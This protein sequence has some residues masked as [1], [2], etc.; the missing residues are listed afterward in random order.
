MKYE[1]QL[2]RWAK[3]AG[4]IAH[5]R[6]RSG[7]TLLLNQLFILPVLAYQYFVAPH[8]ANCCRFYPCCSDY[9]KAAIIKHGVIK[10]IGLGIKRLT[11]CHPW[12]GSGYDPVS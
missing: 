1:R 10:G 7:A 12:G 9:T 5:R 2:F 3:L 11:R 6:L 4:L 8:I